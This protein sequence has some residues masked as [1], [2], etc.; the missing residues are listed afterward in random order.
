MKRVES[1]QP[2]AW[3]RA[4]NAAII[5]APIKYRSKSHNAVPAASAS[6]DEQSLAD[7]AVMFRALADPERLRLLV[8]LAGGEASVGE[9][10]GEHKLTTV[11]ARLQLLLVARLVRRRR[12]ARRIFYALA[13]QR[14]VDLVANAM[15]H[16]GELH[17]HP[18]ITRTNPK[19][20]RR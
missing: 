12:D 2:A 20:P 10:A 3:A 11:S 9:L 15:E 19:G 6:A 18:P 4:S 17:E 1:G 8:R 16:V 14:V 5:D 13:D 7:V